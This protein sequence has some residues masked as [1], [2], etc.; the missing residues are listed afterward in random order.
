M[1]KLFKVFIVLALVFGITGCSTNK[2]Q[3]IELKPDQL[4][5]KWDGNNYNNPAIELTFSM[6]VEW[7]KAEEE[8][9]KTFE[10]LLVT[11]GRD[12]NKDSS[13]IDL[14]VF[15][16]NGE[17][18]ISVAFEDLKSLNKEFKNEDEYYA[19]FV[20]ELKS[21]TEHTVKI[22]E[23]ND[24]K[25]GAVNYRSFKILVDVESG[26]V[27]NHYLLRKVDNYM[28]VICLVITNEGTQD[29]LKLFS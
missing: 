16:N 5:G 19:A 28:V 2:D 23:I 27:T 4:K 17:S 15:E 26:Y 14:L 24:Q 13:F 7:E 3:P 10:D 22:G 25:V 9:L 20:E 12:L 8:E 29:Y 21:D 11:E 18:S 6:P 1:K